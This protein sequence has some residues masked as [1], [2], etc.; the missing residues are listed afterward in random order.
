MCSLL[1]SPYEAVRYGAFRESV[2]V[3]LPSEQ[4]LRER[5]AHEATTRFLKTT[6]LAQR[7]ANQKLEAVEVGDTVKEAVYGYD[8]YCDSKSRW[9]TDTAESLVV[10][11]ILQNSPEP[12]EELYDQGLLEAYAV[13]LAELP[14]DA[15]SGN[16]IHEVT[17]KHFLVKADALFLPAN[18]KMYAKMMGS[19]VKFSM[20]D[21]KLHAYYKTPETDCFMAEQ[22]PL[23]LKSILQD[24][25]EAIKQLQK[26][27]YLNK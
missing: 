1:G 22:A 9:N 6:N 16:R 12:M 25:P 10:K 8:V 4:V 26:E 14:K 18:P 7:L 3:K 21:M 13:S 17:N 19:D 27:G 11:S 5:I 20:I 23:L 15:V 2:R 24:S